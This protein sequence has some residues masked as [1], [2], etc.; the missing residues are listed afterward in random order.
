MDQS[1]QTQNRRHRRSNVMLRA[2]LETPGGPLA[3][4]LRNLSQEGALVKGEDL[5]EAGSRVLFHRDGLSVPS[6]VAWSHC[7]HAG[8]A[9]DF[10]LYPKEIL[11]HIP[12]RQ[13]KAAPPPNKRPGLSSRPLTAAERALIERWATEGVTSK[14]GE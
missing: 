13:Q 6:K 9:F 4:L 7:G 5:P 8:I 10:P 1:L 11:R 3:V 12:E 14:L 2:T